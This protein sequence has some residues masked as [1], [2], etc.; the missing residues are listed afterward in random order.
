[1]DTTVAMMMVT[2][3]NPEIN[4]LLPQIL[5]SKVSQSTAN[6]TKSLLKTAYKRN[7]KMLQFHEKIVYSRQVFYRWFDDLKLIL[8]SQQATANTILIPI[9]EL[10]KHF[11]T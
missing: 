8:A 3:T 9:V 10:I 7:L 4:T 5:K 1:M 2:N 11:M 6:L